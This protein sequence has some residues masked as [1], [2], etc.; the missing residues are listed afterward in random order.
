MPGNDSE[1]SGDVMPA[2]PLASVHI[3]KLRIPI[4]SHFLMEIYVKKIFSIFVFSLFKFFN[5]D[6]T[7]YN[8]FTHIA[9]Q[10]L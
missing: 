8:Y 2:L 5:Y 10:A 3:N 1:K 4:T 6:F 9:V 7:I